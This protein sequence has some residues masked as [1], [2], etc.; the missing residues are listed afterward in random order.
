M[1]HLWNNKSQRQL[2]TFHGKEGLECVC[3]CL[4][5]CVMVSGGRIVRSDRGGVLVGMGGLCVIWDSTLPWDLS[6]IYPCTPLPCFSGG[7]ERRREW[8]TFL[9]IIS[10]GEWRLQG[11]QTLILMRRRPRIRS[12]SEAAS[13][14]LPGFYFISVMETQHSSLLFGSRDGTCRSEGWRGIHNENIVGFTIKM[15][16]QYQNIL[17]PSWR[18]D[19]LTFTWYGPTTYKHKAIDSHLI[20]F[21]PEDLVSH[22]MWHHICWICLPSM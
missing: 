6:Q 1:K 16:L 8:E 13:N 9:G 4:C 17:M 10:H 15:T 2:F 14:T 3:M 21:C 7:Y 22:E 18:R 5:P 11:D 20:T 19:S 12:C